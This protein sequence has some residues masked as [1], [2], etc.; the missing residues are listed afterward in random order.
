MTDL[1]QY[2][3]ATR[4]RPLLD[5]NEERR[6]ARLVREGLEA[7]SRRNSN[8]TCSAEDHAAITAGSDARV[9]LVESNLRLVISVART[10]P[11]HTLADISDLVQAGN[12]GLMVAAEQ[13]DPEKGFRFSTYA[14]VRI[15]QAIA[16]ALDRDTPALRMPYDVVN[17]LRRDL[18]TAGADGHGM[19]GTLAALEL[20]YSSVSLDRPIVE[21]STILADLLPSTADNPA[22]LVADA[23]HRASVRNLLGALP[24]LHRS[25]VAG[26][27]GFWGGEPKSV[28]FIATTLGVSERR[29]RRLLSEGLQIVGTRI[30]DASS[31]FG[32]VRA[33][34]NDSL[35]A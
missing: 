1:R 17:A 31:G 6:L 21:G 32:S 10:F 27:F 5:A 8:G 12:Q 33:D 25:A 14:T 16:R 34:D 9:V 22:E 15:K 7:E 26:R 3:E 28:R 20:A 24:K 18:R 29:V 4:R 13:F 35:S 30:H 11:T 23:I 2:L 19:T